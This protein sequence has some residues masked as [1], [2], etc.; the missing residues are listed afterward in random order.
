MNNSIFQTIASDKQARTG[1][2]KTKST[3]VETPHF[4][5]VV[6]RFNQNTIGPMDYYTL[7]AGS[8]Q[9]LAYSAVICNS[10]IYYFDHIKDLNHRDER[11]IQQFLN[12]KKCIFTDSGGF[13]TSHFSP[14]R[15]EKLPSGILFKDPF[16][17]REIL[18]TPKISMQIQKQMDCDVAMALDDMPNWNSSISNFEKAIYRSKEWAEQCCESKS[19]NGQL[20]FGICQG[21]EYENL[22]R[23]SAL[24]NNQLEFDGIALGGIALCPEQSTRK[25]MVEFSLPFIDE[26]KIRYVMGVGNPIDILNMV[27][28]GIDLFDA[29][30]P[31]IEA[32]R[33]NYISRFGITNLLTGKNICKIIKQSQCSCFLCETD[34]IISLLADPKNKLGLLTKLCQVH[35]LQFMNNLMTDIRA[36]IANHDFSQFREEFNL[37]FNVT[38]F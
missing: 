34:D 5:P 29:A 31:T 15:S 8:E 20:L 38:N 24:I 28:M 35:N 9:C 11:S 19:N 4:M 12:R 25:K 36:A 26:S 13:Q 3:H 23:K 18:L 22:R 37:T 32:K 17:Q 33:L 1:V 30:Y 2:L 16:S 21:G 27:S 7:G 14:I 6:T 10:L